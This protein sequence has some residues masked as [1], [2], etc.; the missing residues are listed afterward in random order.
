MVEDFFSQS[1]NQKQ[2]IFFFLRET[3]FKD[4]A[5][6]VSK[7]ECIFCVVFADMWAAGLPK[8]DWWSQ[9][10]KPQHADVCRGHL[11]CA[12]ALGA[13]LIFLCS[14]GNSYSTVL[15]TH[16]LHNSFVI[17]DDKKYLLSLNW[18][19][20]WLCCFRYKLFKIWKYFYFGNVLDSEL[21][22]SWICLGFPVLS[23]KAWGTI[24]RILGTFI[25]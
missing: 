2:R 8:T 1:L 9:G 19:F 5:I 4:Y 10:S 7:T 6:A 24:K 22:R 21:V 11:S 15:C 23:K 13:R 12:T 18:I 3:H 17:P 16:I 20:S 25:S 14:S